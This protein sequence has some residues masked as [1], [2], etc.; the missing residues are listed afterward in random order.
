MI[1]S[2]A[3]LSRHRPTRGPAAK[4]LWTGTGLDRC[5]TGRA[6]AQAR[7]QPLR[8]GPA[9]CRCRS[10]P[11]PRAGDGAS[12]PFI[13]DLSATATI[14][15]TQ[16]FAAQSVWGDIHVD[17]VNLYV[18]TCWAKLERSVPQCRVVTLAF[19]VL[20]EPLAHHETARIWARRAASVAE[21]WKSR[22]NVG[23]TR[24]LATKN[25]NFLTR[26]VTRC[27]GAWTLAGAA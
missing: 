3:A 18:A 16:S 10:R 25:R 11:R 21:R 19:P 26:L 27:P 24:A 17:P 13:H 23:C 14:R 12:G 4:N 20:W 9:Q 6:T 2:G 5:V 1:R 7:S 22:I 15:C 8:M